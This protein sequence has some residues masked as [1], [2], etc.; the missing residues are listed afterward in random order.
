MLILLTNGWYV[1]PPSYFRLICLTLVAVVVTHRSVFL[2]AGWRVGEYTHAHIAS[3]IVLTCSCAA[4]DPTKEEDDLS[5]AVSTFL[6]SYVPIVRPQPATSCPIKCTDT[7]S[8][9][10]HFLSSLRS[11]TRSS[12]RRTWCSSRRWTSTLCTSRARSQ[13]RTS[14]ACESASSASCLSFENGQVGMCMI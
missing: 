7:G 11:A 3:N 4:D 1:P 5:T 8:T 2:H 12:T 14:P 6:S 13:T 9:H 10:S